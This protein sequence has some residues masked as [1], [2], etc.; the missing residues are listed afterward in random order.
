[1]C[2]AHEELRK[3]LKQMIREKG[4]SYESFALGFS[5]FLDKK[6]EG[7]KEQQKLA[8]FNKYLKRTK[9]EELIY[10]ENFSWDGRYRKFMSGYIQSLN[11]GEVC[12]IKEFL[13]S[14]PEQKK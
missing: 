12:L 11:Y 1:M 7:L 8:H 6:G 4:L 9:K 2:M 5:E 13:Q 3:E 10:H 14:Y